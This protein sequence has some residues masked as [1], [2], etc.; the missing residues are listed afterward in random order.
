MQSF[1]GGNPGNNELQVNPEVLLLV[2]RSCW[3]KLQNAD[4]V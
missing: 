2:F 4:E 3:F 1:L